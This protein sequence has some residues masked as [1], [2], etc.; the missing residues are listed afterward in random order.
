MAKIT[1]KIKAERRGSRGK[2]PKTSEAIAREKIA[3]LLCL[4]DFH[5]DPNCTTETILR[6]LRQIEERNCKNPKQHSSSGMTVIRKITFKFDGKKYVNQAAPPDASYNLDSENPKMISYDG[7][8]GDQKSFQQQPKKKKNGNEDHGDHIVMENPSC[9]DDNMK[10]GDFITSIGGSEA[11]LVIRKTL[12]KSDCDKG[13][14]RL[15]IPAIQVKNP[16][17]LAVDEKRRLEM[18]ECI[19]VDV[20]DPQRR[21]W[22]LNLAQW[23]MKNENYALRTKWK[24]I[25]CANG[26]KENTVI[27]VFSFRLQQKLCF[28]VVRD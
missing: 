2:F 1:K 11:E 26:F 27:R 9:S 23:K 14:G 10:V 12:T 21:K 19:S 8:E 15:L 24:N 18:K 28:A 7:K 3:I 6:R 25:V 4:L 16:G 17:F 5:D 22:T 13:L 20:F